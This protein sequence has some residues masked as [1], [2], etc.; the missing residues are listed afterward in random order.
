MDFIFRRIYVGQVKAVIFDLAGT[1]VDY[2]SCAPAGVFVELFRNHGIEISNSQARVPM[3]MH[4]RDHI[5]VLLQMEDVSKKWKEKYGKAWSDG[6]LDMLYERFVPLQIG[7]LERYSTLIPGTV[8]MAEELRSQG[9]RIGVTTGYNTDMMQIVLDAVKKQGFVPDSAICVSNVPKGRPAPWMIYQTMQ[10]LGVFPPESIVSVG[11]T[12]PD[13][14]SALNAGIWSLGV[15]KTGNMM[16]L[17]EKEVASLPEDELEKRLASAYETM[18]RKGAHLVIDGVEDCVESID[19]ISFM[20][21]E[22]ER[23]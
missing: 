15:A 11:D 1:T 8:E 10:E 22:G 21:A 9:I 3:G 14:E 16:G 23:P 17:N 4:K 12:I 6:D 13:I 18:Y 7:C 20:L 19:E 2:G 5:Q